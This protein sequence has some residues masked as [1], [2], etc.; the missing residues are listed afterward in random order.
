MKYHHVDVFASQICHGNGL[1]VVF[2]DHFLSDGMMLGIA[3]EFK[4][5]E[6]AFV[7]PKQDGSYPVRI[8]TIQEELQFAGHPVLGVGALLHRLDYPDQISQSISIALGQ[9]MIEVQSHRKGDSYWVGMAQGQ[10]GFICTLETHQ[11]A[12]LCAL[13]NLMPT[14]L[15]QGFP[16]EVVSTGLPYLLV[17]VTGA[18]S[19]VRIKGE[20]FEEY[21]SQFGA[22]FMYMFDPATLEC[23]TWDNTG[24]F[25]DIATGS[26]AGPLV[27]YLVKHHLYGYGE[28]IQIHQ[29]AYVG[30]PSH[31]TGWWSD[32]KEDTGI[33]IEGE[34]V[35]FADGELYI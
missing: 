23:R 14:D 20:G 10:P 22:K 35:M 19:K 13:I 27:A 15:A 3:Q 2:P 29:G 18:L 34:V 12:Q 1:T 31:I 7:F 21:L 25:E 32:H 8:F 26:A 17:P 4:Q 6:T 24:L 9:R 30:R 16:L 33:H 11:Y 5:Y 28:P